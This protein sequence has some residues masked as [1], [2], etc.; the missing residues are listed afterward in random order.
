MFIVWSVERSFQILYSQQNLNYQ[1]MRSFVK[2]VIANVIIIAVV[3]VVVDVRKHT[4]TDK[5]KV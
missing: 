3:I 1:N 4:K 5:E 2:V